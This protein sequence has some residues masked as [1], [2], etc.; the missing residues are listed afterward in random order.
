MS[1]LAQIPRHLVAE[2][3]QV[4]RDHVE[5]LT[6]PQVASFTQEFHRR[7]KNQSTAYL[8]WFLFG[9]HYLYLERWSIWLLYLISGAGCGIW[10]IVDL[11]RIPGEVT[12]RNA[13]IAVQLAKDFSAIQK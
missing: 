7:R 10:G 11:F 13:D 12:Q 6:P 4:V 1:N 9:A 5:T 3:P 2:L 8:L